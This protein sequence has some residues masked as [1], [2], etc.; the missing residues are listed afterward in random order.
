MFDKLLLV[1]MLLLLPVSALLTRYYLA[2]SAQ[3][4]VSVESLEKVDVMLNQLQQTISQ[5]KEPEEGPD[6]IISSV[7]YATESGVLNVSGVA[8]KGNLSVRISTLEKEKKTS[9][10][11]ASE[12][13]VLGESVAEKA[14]TTSADG[15][16][17]YEYEVEGN[18]KELET[19]EVRIEQGQVNK[20]LIYYFGKG[21]FEQI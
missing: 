19:I 5:K 4:T 1:I 7:F 10:A 3:P 20:T 9:S 12:S 13:A 6:F 21:T 11:T 17:G 8:P 2:K 18:D 15:I 16:F 14:V